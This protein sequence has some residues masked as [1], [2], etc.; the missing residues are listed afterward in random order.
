MALFLEL[1]S[2]SALRKG[3]Y[4]AQQEFLNMQEMPLY[5]L[6][7]SRLACPKKTHGS[8]DMNPVVLGTRACAKSHTTH[9]KVIVLVILFLINA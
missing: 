5:M 9:L 6:S 2:T 1:P 7:C 4:S 8:M 3:S